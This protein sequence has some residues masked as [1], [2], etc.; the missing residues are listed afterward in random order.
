M[1]IETC[2][3]GNAQWVL[4]HIISFNYPEKITEENK[5]VKKDMYNYL[6]SLGSVLPCPK[7]KEHYFENINKSINGYTLDDS[8]NSKDKFTRWM[9]ELHNLVN[10][11]TGKTVYPT[12]KEVYNRYNPLVSSSC[13]D[14]CN[15]DTGD[16]YCKVEFVKKSDGNMFDLNYEKMIIFAL[17]LIICAGLGY[18]FWPKKTHV[19][20]KL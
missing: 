2:I 14:S 16:T 20:R 7:C 10:K 15:S 1:T 19:V 3:W 5:Q 12:Y 9:Y 8:L 13:S 17:V 4:L 11:Q 6:I 18:Y